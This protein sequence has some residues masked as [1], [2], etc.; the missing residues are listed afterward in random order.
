MEDTL[1]IKPIFNNYC[2]QVIDIVR[3]IQ[4]VEFNLPIT[5]DQQPDLK[6]IETNYHQGGGNFWGAFWGDELIGTIALINCGHNTGCV[7]KMFVKKEYRGR[8]TGAAQQLLNV[9][10]DYCRS[11]QIVH[12]YLGTVHQLKAAHRFYERNGF[13]AIEVDDLPDYFPLMKT[14]N[15]FFQLHLV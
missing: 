8:A 3:T 15:M 12:V 2:D 4:Q 1:T 5:I 14:D 6:D 9:M 13:S 10:L 11:K 7:R